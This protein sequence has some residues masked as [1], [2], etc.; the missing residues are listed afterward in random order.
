MGRKWGHKWREESFLVGHCIV[1]FFLFL[2]MDDMHTFDA[3]QCI[4][5]DFIMDKDSKLG[6]CWLSFQADDRMQAAAKGFL[7]QAQG[8]D[9][10]GPHSF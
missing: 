5:I 7:P 3:V 10:S 2:A 8:V 6:F 9:G 1:N 4:P